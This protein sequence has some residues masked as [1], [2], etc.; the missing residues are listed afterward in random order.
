MKGCEHASGWVWF[1]VA[2][3][4]KQNRKRLLPLS[5]RIRDHLET[6]RGAD[7]ER[8]VPLK[9]GRTHNYHWQQIVEAAGVDSRIRL[10]EGRGIP[11]FRKGCSVH[12]EAISEEIADYVL[13]HRAKSMRGRHY[14]QTARKVCQWVESV[15][16]SAEDA[17]RREQILKSVAEL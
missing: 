13:G 10:S 17:A 12:W 11:S 2:K 5:Q 8:V 3:A 1:P 9:S 6:W 16:F 15:P 14:G 7:A 4:E